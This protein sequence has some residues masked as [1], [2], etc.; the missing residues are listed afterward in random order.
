VDGR[1]MVVAGFGFRRISWVGH[2]FLVMISFFFG[3]CHFSAATDSMI[4][5]WQSTQVT[6]RRAMPNVKTSSKRNLRPKTMYVSH[7]PSLPT[8]QIWDPLQHIA[9]QWRPRTVVTSNPC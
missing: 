6:A 3:I 8:Q 9:Y 1:Y 5:F 4:H 7:P 2:F